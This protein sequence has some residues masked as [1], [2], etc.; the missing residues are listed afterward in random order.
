MRDSFIYECCKEILPPENLTCQ[1]T[2]VGTVLSWDPVP[3]ADTYT[4][5]V[6][7]N[8]TACCRTGIP[9]VSLLPITTTGTSV[10]IDPQ[11]EC[12]SWYVVSNCAD[13]TSD[14]SRVACS[15]TRVVDPCR[16]LSAP[17]NLDCTAGL[18]GYTLSWDPAL[19]ATQYQVYISVNDTT[20]CRNGLPNYVL[21]P[22]TTSGTAISIPNTYKCFAWWVIAVCEDGTTSRRSSIACSCSFIKQRG[23][24]EEEFDGLEVLVS[25]NPS[26][27]FVTF[28]LRFYGSLLLSSFT[29]MDPHF[30]VSSSLFIFLLFPSL[31]LCYHQFL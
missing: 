29:S 1:A 9:P 26:S 10:T 12:F 5:Y 31:T 2:P 8:D 14:R 21:F 17:T 6:T 24:L 13:V 22:I 3:D 20:C 19:G 16:E 25:P 7:P 18:S 15:C 11:W 28:E 27:D 4:V 30:F 23:S